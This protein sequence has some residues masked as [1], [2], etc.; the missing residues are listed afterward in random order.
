MAMAMA[1]IVDI[2]TKALENREK[3]CSLYLDLKKAFDTVNIQI[4]LDKLCLIGVQGSALEMLKSYLS[5]RLQRVRANGFVSEDNEITLG[6]P[7]GSIL[8]PLLFLIYIN[9]LPN[10]S[11][12]AKFF[13]FADDTAI[14]VKGSTY[15]DLQ[16]QIDYLMPQLTD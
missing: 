2:I 13:L 4:L 15:N 8:G 5:N 9:D 14:I 16:E 11:D 7:Q 3:V 1:L 10:I 6:V 12:S